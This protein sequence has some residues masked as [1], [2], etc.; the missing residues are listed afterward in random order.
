[1][2]GLFLLLYVSRTQYFSLSTG[3]LG[4]VKEVSSQARVIQVEPA[5]DTDRVKEEIQN[6]IKQIQSLSGRGEKTRSFTASPAGE[7]FFIDTYYG[8]LSNL[9][10][11]VQQLQKD[12]FMDNLPKTL[13]CILS[14]QQDC[15]VE[16]ELTQTVAADLVQPLL[17]FLASLKTQT[18][19]PV[20]KNYRGLLDSMATAFDGFQET[21]IKILSSIPGSGNLMS[22]LSYIA[23]AALANVS[24]LMASLLQV[25]VDYIKIALQFAIRVPTFNEE[26]ET[27]EEGKTSS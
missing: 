12:G 20:N 17:A 19:V 7:A 9:V 11:L 24:T 16:G 21:L 4:D 27:C 6:V 1:M 10:A 3:I 2:R 8:T 22:T 15:G 13:V 14:G 5:E 26:T 18:C 23:D 25:P